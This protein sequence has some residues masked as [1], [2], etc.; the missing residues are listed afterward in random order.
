MIGYGYGGVSPLVRLHNEVGRRRYRVEIR[1]IRMHVQLN[2]LV[3][4]S[5]ALRYGLYR[6][7]RLRLDNE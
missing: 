6:H 1:H 4:G 5:V 2:T 7:Y 3:F